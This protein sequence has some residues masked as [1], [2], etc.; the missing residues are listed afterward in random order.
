MNEVNFGWYSCSWI[1]KSL[2]SIHNFTPEINI[3]SRTVQVPRTICTLEKACKLLWM[4]KISS[5]TMIT[6]QF[7]CAWISV[8]EQVGSHVQ[9]MNYIPYCCL[10]AAVFWCQRMISQSNGKQKI[11]SF[12]KDVKCYEAVRDF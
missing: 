3:R 9:K 8:T 5:L 7:V 6:V 10:R 12:Y 11:T 1:L 2:F 4:L